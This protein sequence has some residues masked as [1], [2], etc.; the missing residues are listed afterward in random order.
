MQINIIYKDGQNIEIKSSKTLRIFKVINT[1]SYTLVE[2]NITVDICLNNEYV[3]VK[4][5]R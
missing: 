3:I 1:L 2:F 5:S 4:L